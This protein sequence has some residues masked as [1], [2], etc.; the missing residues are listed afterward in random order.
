[1]EIYLSKE[2]I[3]KILETINKFPDGCNEAG[4]YKFEHSYCGIGSSLDMI[5]NMSIKGQKGEF[6]IEILGSEDW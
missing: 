4:N 3:E 1:M 2:N 6:R 5:I